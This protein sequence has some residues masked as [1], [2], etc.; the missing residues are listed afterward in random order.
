MSIRMTL[1]TVEHNEEDETFEYSMM[2]GWTEGCRLNWEYLESKLLSVANKMRHSV[3]N[4]CALRSGDRDDAK[5]YQLTYRKEELYRATCV[6]QFRCT[7]CNIPK[8]LRHRDSKDV[9]GTSNPIARIQKPDTMTLVLAAAIVQTP[10][11]AD[12]WNTV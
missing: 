7:S 5:G 8:A 6:R 3:V 10:P 4:L 1:G 12:E 9:F 2:F 11:N